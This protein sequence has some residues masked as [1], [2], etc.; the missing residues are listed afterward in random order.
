MSTKYSLHLR[1]T[2]NG[3]GASSPWNE[4]SPS[5]YVLGDVYPTTRNGLTFGYTSASSTFRS[6]SGTANNARIS[7]RHQLAAADKLRVD[8]PDGAGNYNLWM[9][10]GALNAATATGCSIY[11][12]D[13]TTILASIGMFSPPSGSV[14]DASGTQLTFAQWLTSNTPL[15][16]TFSGDHFYV[17]RNVPNGNPSGYFNTIE[18]QLQA[19]T[20]TNA[21]LTNDVGDALATIYAGQPPGK[22]IAKITAAGAQSFSLAGTLAGYFSV[23]LQGDGHYWI[24]G[25]SSRLPDAASGTL[26]VVQT[27]ANGSNSPYSTDV[28]G[29]TGSV[30]ITSSQGR[31]TDASVLGLI[32][33][34][35]YLKRKTV[36][37]ACA[38]VFAGWTNQTFA[39]DVAVTSAAALQTAMSNAV[40]A[41]T[42]TSWHRIRLQ[43][44]GDW[45]TN[46]AI[47]AGDFGT[48]GLLITNDTGHDPQIAGTLTNSGRLMIGWHFDNVTFSLGSI[49]ANS[50]Q[51]TISAPSALPGHKI[52][53]TNS[54]IGTYY[55][56]GFSVSNFNSW[57]I[58]LQADTCED[59]VLRN[60]T[61]RGV[62]HFIVY[63]N[64][65][66][67]VADQGNDF[68]LVYGDIL[69]TNK[70]FRAASPYYAD[71]YVRLA[72]FVCRDQP[73][74][75]TTLD[76][77][78]ALH[79]DLVQTQTPIET[80]STGQ[81]ITAGQVRINLN[82]NKVYTAT[83]TGTTAASGTGPSGTGTGIV[84]NTVT[85]NYLKDYTPPALHMLIENGLIVAGGTTSYVDTSNNKLAMP[86][87]DMLI[88]S[89]T[90]VTS[91]SATEF[92]YINNLAASPD[93][94]GLAPINADVYAEFNTMVGPGEIPAYDASHALNALEKSL[95]VTG[96]GTLRA[97]GNIVGVSGGNA[98]ISV[99][100]TAVLVAENNIVAGFDGATAAG[101]K[102]T[103]MLVGSFSQR[104]GDSRWIYTA[105]DTIAVDAKTVQSTYSKMMRPKTGRYGARLK[106]LHTLTIGDSAAHGQTVTLEIDP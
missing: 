1:A 74:V 69:D 36:V 58:F 47:P 83:T 81:S 13:N 31:P 95:Q 24:V 86:G 40:A 64:V 53:V 17:A 14:V 50:Y 25:G 52:A 101:Q 49:P 23:A 48:G 100:G 2:A 106:E 32:S 43:T 29:G 7:G 46:I 20:L 105:D 51:F 82:A 96:S 12:S 10:M 77:S 11:D 67:L 99:L 61:V 71:S 60:N 22:K 56:A 102:P 54:R 76:R 34:Q 79:A 8:L 15:A 104:A 16:L 59:L 98:F 28:I 88:D 78:S 4:V 89:L 26:Q 55:G 44:G 21:T 18:F 45:T 5:A 62:Q 41:K 103:D 91:A 39:T 97:M 92:I 73:D 3:T 93:Q 85:W 75:F 65:K 80:W 70:T 90:G 42:G 72:N 63:G 94:Y 87:R 6:D 30:T 19:I 57:G 27:D 9:A 37:D 84:D 33:T 66:H 68:A 35:T 38:S